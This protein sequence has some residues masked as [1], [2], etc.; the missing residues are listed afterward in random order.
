MACPIKPN[1][2][3]YSVYRMTPIRPNAVEPR[4]VMS[5]PRPA[6]APVHQGNP[7]DP[8]FFKVP[9][10]V[11]DTGLFRG[12]RPAGSRAGNPVACSMQRG[13]DGRSAAFLGHGSRGVRSI[14][15]GAG[16]RRRRTQHVPDL[17][18]ERKC[19]RRNGRIRRLT[20]PA[21]ARAPVMAGRLH[22]RHI[23]CV[24]AQG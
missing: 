21:G 17:Q 15:P 20:E 6:Q 4:P 2:G 22:R 8:C 7:D 23:G 19:C 24:I 16:R 3:D 12:I 10:P 13:D 14:F 1:A 11:R 9:D 5:N 18:A